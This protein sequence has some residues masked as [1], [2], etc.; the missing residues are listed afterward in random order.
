MKTT[1]LKLTQSCLGPKPWDLPL[2]TKKEV[3]RHS[4]RDLMLFCER[5]PT[6]SQGTCANLEKDTGGAPQ[7]RVQGGGGERLASTGT[8]RSKSGLFLQAPVP[9]LAKVAPLLPPESTP[10]LKSGK[11]PISLLNHQQLCA[12]VCSFMS[13]GTTARVYDPAKHSPYAYL[14]PSIML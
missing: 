7:A 6:S 10:P 2:V 5:S 13:S 14:H 11:L 12:C 3:A 9:P 4:T 1:L 8:P